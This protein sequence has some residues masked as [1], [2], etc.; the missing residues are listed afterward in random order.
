[1]EIPCFIFADD[2]EDYVQ[3]RG[4]LFFYMYKLPFP[5]ALKNDELIKNIECFDFEI[6]VKEVRKFMNEQGVVEL[7]DASKKV[8]D[9][10][11]REK[12]FGK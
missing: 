1:M 9:L 5:V 6:Y 7:G 3:N 2:L 10:I 8:V 4:D 11:E 12:H